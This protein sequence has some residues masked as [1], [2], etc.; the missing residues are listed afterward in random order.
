MA[1]HGISR[2]GEAIVKPETENLEKKMKG[3]LTKL[4]STSKPFPE[5]KFKALFL[6]WV[7]CNNII[8]RQSVSQNLREMF[9]LLDSSALK[10]L[11]TSHNTT[12]Q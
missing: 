1:I 7:I 9:A 3:T 8:L 5:D 2:E 12:R 11:P 4:W 6:K 10:V